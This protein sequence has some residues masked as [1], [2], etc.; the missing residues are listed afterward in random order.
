MLTKSEHDYSQTRIGFHENI[1][2]IL[3][4]L[5]SLAKVKI[6]YFGKLA[7]NMQNGQHS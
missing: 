7:M 4:S 2:A 6:L 5:S 3:A 1:I